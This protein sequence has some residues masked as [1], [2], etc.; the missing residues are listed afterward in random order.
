MTRAGT[1]MPPELCAGVA[2][3]VVVETVFGY[4]GMGLLAV[5][6][7][8]TRDLP[9]IQAFVVVVGLFVI[10]MNLLVDGAYAV[11]NPRLRQA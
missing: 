11:L 6:S 3:A 1:R 4:P 9:V 7:I 2:G 10:L 8:A 5:Q